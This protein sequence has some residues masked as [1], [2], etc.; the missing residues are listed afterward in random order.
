MEEKYIIRNVIIV[1]VNGR[2]EIIENG[3]I[4]VEGNRILDIGPSA[5][6]AKKYTVKKTINARG[7][8]AMPG[9]VNGH[10][11]LCVPPPRATYDDKDIMQYFTEI[12]PFV[13]G[14]FTEDA[15]YKISLLGALEALKSGITFLNSYGH[16]TQSLE[17]AEIKALEKLG[18]KAM[19]CTWMQDLMHPL[20]LSGEEQLKQAVS[21]AEEYA[22][23]DK[24]KFALG[25]VAI[26][27][28]LMVSTG[29]FL[30]GI[31]AISKKYNLKVHTHGLHM[32]GE[33]E[34]PLDLWQKSGLVNSNMIAVH[35]LGAGH[36]N[37]RTF[38]K[39]NISVVHCPSVWAKLG[40]P[41]TAWIPLKEMVKAGINVSMGTDGPGLNSKTDL[42]REMGECGLLNNFVSVQPWLRPEAILRMAT[43]NG[44]RTLGMENEIGSLEKG[45]RADIILLDFNK[46]H[47]KPLNNIVGLLVYAATGQD[48]DTVIIDGK[49]IMKSREVLGIDEE[50]IMEDAQEAFEKLYNDA[51]WKTSLDVAK[52]PKIPILLR[53]PHKMEMMKVITR[54]AGKKIFGK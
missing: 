47:L 12:Y 43:I 25:P 34:I 1:T 27:E 4:V 32:S 46:P 26:D 45:K 37:I 36:E 24:I 16:L 40:R 22:F 48:V 15:V 50:K 18:L 8:V 20:N 42:L 17:K 44:A 7:M 30:D 2:N 35:C 33:K 31:A 3:S 14:K 10:I 23:N 13:A 11:H 9:L 53:M 29:K 6:I 21:L 19:V 49:I 51:G 5:D 52:K 39:N 54:W 41:D 28:G 38:K